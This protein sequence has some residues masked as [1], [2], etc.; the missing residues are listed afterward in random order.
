[1]PKEL[2]MASEETMDYLVLW[3]VEWLLVSAL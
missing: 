3:L 2:P 1:M